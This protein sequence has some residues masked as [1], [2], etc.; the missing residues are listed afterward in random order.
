MQRAG[1]VGAGAGCGAQEREA[2]LVL[3]EQRLEEAQAAWEQESRRER[4]AAEEALRQAATQAE[5]YAKQVRPALP[6]PAPRRP[7]P[8]CTTCSPAGHGPPC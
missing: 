6:C 2:S 4:G 1:R 8:S 5:G 7:A 3:R